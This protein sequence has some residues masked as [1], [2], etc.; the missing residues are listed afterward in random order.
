MKAKLPSNFEISAVL[1]ESIKS[2]TCN[3]LS[4]RIKDLSLHFHL[5]HP[6]PS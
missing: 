6:E 5:K 4:H 2:N 1:P 3:Y